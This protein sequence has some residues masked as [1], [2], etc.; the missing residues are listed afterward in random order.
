VETLAFQYLCARSEGWEL[1]WRPHRLE[2][3]AVEAPEALKSIEP[4]RGI[5]F[6]APHYGPPGGKSAL[7]RA[8]GRVEVAVG[9][10]LH[11]AEAPRGYNG[12][13]N[14]QVRTLLVRNGYAVVRAQGSGARFAKTLQAGGRVLINFDVPGTTPVRFLGKTVELRTGTARLAEKTDAVIVPVLPMRRGG[15]WRLHLDEPIDPRQH[16]DWLTLLQAVADVHSRLILQ[17][18][19]HLESPLRDG[20]WSVATRDGW[21]A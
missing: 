20:G 16:P 10:H 3:M 2:T 9:E 13:Q 17:A 6:S 15:G 18:P 14:E 21:R 7:P 5:L 1:A 12:Y 11:A 8:V 19:E 4:G